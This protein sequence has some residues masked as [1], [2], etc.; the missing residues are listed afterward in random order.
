[1][2]R[3]ASKSIDDIMG[4]AKDAGYQTRRVR[5]GVEIL[6]DGQWKKIADIASEATHNAMLLPGLTS[7]PP[8]R[9][10]GVLTERLGEQYIRQS[11]GAV[12][13]DVK[14]AERT[15]KLVQM[16]SE[17]AEN[18]K[19]LG[20]EKRR[21]GSLLIRDDRVLELLGP[22]NKLW[23]S[24]VELESILP[25][26]EALSS[27]S[28]ILKTYNSVGETIELFVIGKPYTR[29]EI[30]SM[31]FAG[32]VDTIKDIFRAPYK[33]DGKATK[34]IDEINEAKDRIIKFD[35]AIQKAARAGDH[36]EVWRLSMEMELT[37]RN[38]RS[39]AR[40][41]DARYA[42]TIGTTAPLRIAG[43]STGDYVDRISY[44][45]MAR[46]KPTELAR[47]LVDMPMAERTR[48][49]NELDE[50]ARVRIASDI[51]RVARLPKIERP[52]L[53]IGVSKS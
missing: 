42:A 48:V 11:M 47:V 8:V 13:S 39:L 3:N 32:T 45:E 50:P 37:S 2:V 10:Q 17:I 4:I 5:H 26:G 44:R 19:N 7:P 51:D 25:P 9:V 36:Q 1:M 34:I 15:K 41:L 21:P 38:M 14:A 35:R 6:L 33:I 18:V 27:P 31:K 49:L 20:L 24:G 46:T 23:K 40:A 29:A 30:M 16:S 43:V 22:S 53:K 28:Q 52:R 12:A